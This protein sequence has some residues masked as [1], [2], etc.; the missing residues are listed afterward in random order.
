MWAAQ[1]VNVCGNGVDEDCVGGDAACAAAV[2]PTCSDGA[3]NGGET[4]DSCPSD[5]GTCQCVPTTLCSTLGCG[6]T[7]S[8]ETKQACYGTFGIISI[9]GGRQVG[10]CEGRPYTPIKADVTIRAKEIIKTVKPVVY[11]GKLVKL[12]TLVFTPER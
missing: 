8:S 7:N 1:P 3:C 5:C 10:C 4:C 2:Q 9:S 12:I 11:H 6:N